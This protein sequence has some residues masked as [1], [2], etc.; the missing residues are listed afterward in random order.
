MFD[1]K[2]LRNF[3][4]ITI[5]IM[6]S[7][8]AIGVVA[9]SSATHV[10][11][12]GDF[13]AVKK[14]VAWF[15]LGL[16]VMGVIISIDYN[17]FGHLATY[18]YVT[19]ILLL[20]AVLFVGTEINGAKSW[21]VIKGLGSIQPSEFVKIIVII[22]FAKHIEKIK[23]NN[24]TDINALKNLFILMLHMMLPILLIMKQPDW[25]TAGVFIG[26]MIILL[27]VAGISYKYI[28]AAFTA[29]A[30]IIPILFFFVMKDYQRER[31]LVFWNPNRDPLGRGY[32]VIQSKIAIGSG[33]L[34]GKGLFHGTQTQLG[35][36]PEQH[37]DFIFSVIG[38]ELGF[39]WS[40]VVVLLFVILLL[41]LLY[42]ATVA[43][44]KFGTYIIIGV[45]A[46]IFF[47]F[48]INVGMTI[49]LAPVTGIP[50]PFISYGGSSLLTNMIAVG[51]VLNVAMRRQK[52]KW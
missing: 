30:A 5:V 31:I 36:L 38:E 46:M 9:I 33:Q 1:K 11:E 16:I 22:S 41:R 24:D 28:I 47:H 3:D 34:Y 6:V 43:K 44:D 42:L 48:L 45:T 32:H 52:I 21:F 51:L 7:L 40:S 10:A 12:T 20:I 17:T 25:G 27:F 18:M 14:Q 15:I 49:G 4:T 19:G 39:I 50:L 8:I 23:E 26:I 35:F 13:W 29:S 37:T 2:L